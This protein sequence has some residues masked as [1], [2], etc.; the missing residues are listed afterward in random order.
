MGKRSKKIILALFTLVLTILIASVVNAVCCTEPGDNYCQ[1]TDQATCADS[2]ESVSCDSLQSICTDV[3]CCKATCESYVTR[4]YCNIA[5]AFV[6]DK[7]CSDESITECQKGCC[8][9]IDS[10]NTPHDC[11]D[12][13][14]HKGIYEKDCV[15]DPL[16]ANKIFYPGEF[17][18][19]CTDLCEAG[20]L[21]KGTIKGFVY[22]GIPK[23]SADDAKVII[24]GDLKNWIYNDKNTGFEF[25]EQSYGSHSI[26]AYYAGYKPKTEN[27][28]LSQA[29]LEI[30]IHLT[31]T[32]DKGHVSGLVREKNTGKLIKNAVV[33]YSNGQDSTDDDAF[34]FIENIDE[35]PITLTATATGYNS[36]SKPITI[37]AGELTTTNFDLTPATTEETGWLTGYVKDTT[38]GDYLNDVVIDVF[39]DN[40]IEGTGISE[41]DFTIPPKKGFYQILELPEGTLKVRASKQ[42][43]Y[44]SADIPIQINKNTGTSLEDIE[45]EP[46]PAECLADLPSPYLELSN[47]KGTKSI[48]IKWNQKCIQELGVTDYKL[49]RNNILIKT[50][51]EEDKIYE[52]EDDGS[53]IGKLRWD[54]TYT[55]KLIALASNQQSIAI[56]TIN[57]GNKFCENKLDEEFCLDNN[58]GNIIP[59]TVRAKCNNQNILS[60][61]EGCAD[62]QICRQLNDLTYCIDPDDCQNLGIDY[63]QG[64]FPNILG[65]FYYSAYAEITCLQNQNNQPRFCYM[66]YY[67]AAGPFTTVD[68]CLN[69]KQDGNCFDYQS[70]QACQQD[71][72]GY[73]DCEWY[74]NYAFAPLG[75]G[76]CYEKS[77]TGTDYC[78]LCS[79][80]NNLFSNVYCTKELCSKLGSCFATG[81][82]CESCTQDSTCELYT[83]REACVGNSQGFEAEICNPD[84]EFKYSKDTCGL[85]RCKWLNNQCIKDGNDDNIADCKENDILCQID[86]TPPTTFISSKPEA[87]ISEETEIRFITDGTSTYYCIDE[88]NCCPDKIVNNNNLVLPNEDFLLKDIK[89]NHTLYFY[90]I[91]TYNN[92]ETIQKEIIYVNTKKPK[93]TFTTLVEDNTESDT[94]SDLT[95]TLNV[96]DK[97]YCEDDLSFGY[98]NTVDSKISQDVATDL[99]VTYSALKDGYYYYTVT[100]RDELGNINET[101]AWLLIDRIKGITYAGPNNNAVVKNPVNIIIRTT[102]KNYCRYKDQNNNWQFMG[103]NK[104]QGIFDPTSGEFKY[105]AT[106]ATLISGTHN[107]DVSCH[108]DH[109]F[110]QHFDSINLAFTVDNIPPTTTPTFETVTGSYVDLISTFS[111]SQ[112]TIRLECADDPTTNF[113][114]KETKYCYDSTDCTPD[115][116]LPV[117]GIF[118]IEDINNTIL[119]YYSVDK[120]GNEE[121]TTCISLTVDST[122]PGISL[123]LEGSQTTGSDNIIISYEPKPIIVVDATETITIVEKHL[124]SGSSGTPELEQ[125][126]NIENKILK[127]Q[128]KENLEKG[129]YTAT[130]KVVD[131]IAGIGN[132]KTA[133][134]TFRVEPSPIDITYIEPKHGVSSKDT[135]NL[136]LLIKQQNECRYTINPDGYG[137]VFHTM[138]PLNKSE[139]NLEIYYKQNFNEI[140]NN[141]YRTLYIACN[142]SLGEIQRGFKYL[143]V[144]KLKP[145]FDKLEAV[146][147]TISDEPVETTLVVDTNKETICKYSTT[148]KD[149][150]AMEGKLSGY[151]NNDFNISH[152]K[153]LEF[154]TA[155]QDYKYY[156]ICEAMNGLKTDGGEVT[157]KV[158][159]TLP[160]A[161]TDQTSDYFSQGSV[162]LEIY[163]NKWSQCSYGT[164][165][166]NITL[167]YTDEG[168]MNKNHKQTL[169]LN[170]G[171]YKYYIKCVKGSETATK[172]I[173]FSIDTSPPDMLYVREIGTADYPDKSPYK[174]RLKGEWKA[175]D[176]Q[177]GIDYYN[178]LLYL[179]KY[180]EDELIDSFTTSDTNGEVTG[181]ELN[182]S[183][184]YYFEVSAVNKVGLWSDNETGDGIIIDTSLS[185]LD[186]NNREKDNDETDIDCGGSCSKGCPDNSSCKENSDCKNGFCHNDICKESTCYDGLKGPKESDKDCGGTCSK[187]C[188][189]DEKCGDDD[190]CKSGSCD[191]SKGICTEGGKCYNNKLD[192]GETDE[193]CGGICLVKC[194]NSDTCEEAYDCESN[195]C[196]E[197]ICVSA[198]KCS[199]NKLDPGETDIDCGGSCSQ[200]RN[201]RSCL[202]D[203]DCSSGN[204]NLDICEEQLDDTD[205]DGLS[206]TWED[207]YN[208]GDLDSELY[209][210]D[211]NEKSDGEEDFDKDGLINTVEEKYRT[212]PHK[213]DTDGDGYTDKEEIDKGTDPL[214]KDDYPESDMLFILFLLVALILL[215]VGGYFGYR[216]YKDMKESK[217]ELPPIKEEQILP[218]P[219]PLAG[220]PEQKTTTKKTF[221]PRTRTELDKKIEEKRKKR[222]KLLS[223]FGFGETLIKKEFEVKEE[224]KP[225]ETFEEGPKIGWVELKTPGR[226]KT[227]SSEKTIFEKLPKLKPGEDVFIALSKMIGAE[228]KQETITE[229]KDVAQKKKLTKEELLT[230]INKF[231]KQKKI[232][233]E[234][235]HNV[236][237]SIL[238]E[239]KNI[240][241]KENKAKL[242]TIIKKEVKTI[243]V[244]STQTA[245]IY[246]KKGCITIKKKKNLKTYKSKKEAQDKKLKP[247]S[248]CFPTKGRK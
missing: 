29:I 106:L 158:D 193:D 107:I 115:I 57:T 188:E 41:T 69:C 237:A 238:E 185:T 37:T 9:Q 67:K 48:K 43:Y 151:D 149:Y 137:Y 53:S 118:T 222:E 155:K 166:S 68:R 241:K 49:Y 81:D 59:L 230:I 216:K 181:L 130:I 19:N 147:H 187:K 146:P 199:N 190:D 3:G 143:R 136:T 164:S 36:E 225:T 18:N 176:N 103:I 8:V 93:F 114:C 144:D 82:S 125:I 226:T 219:K 95:V 28:V 79:S 42:G 134:L 51:K 203:D 214:D 233:E 156:V 197:N 13:Q 133:T 196:I 221:P 34:F 14:D 175:E 160:L 131:G 76:F 66:D 162:D 177:S 154:S 207:R 148:P 194:D 159:L 101:S 21:Q 170:E 100:C 55:Y 180:S 165:S 128:P 215:G 46:L 94:T 74:N 189:V 23:Q 64:Y 122:P 247:C 231:S 84:E 16:Y 248:V 38:S 192:P 234:S 33:S 212:D 75:R 208:E 1:E 2:Y 179:D 168:S 127:L 88:F 39:K 27:I 32:T 47:I 142:N 227:I 141:D 99:S 98:G 61:V 65:M 150:E 4:A 111:S 135:F 243:P 72:C 205:N 5:D 120:G 145:S 92:T 206:D 73:S 31:E 40:I 17:G 245:N 200:C 80:N 171:S 22:Y 169:S 50:F 210:T 202:T 117:N 191:I 229:F 15:A 198:N 11:Y 246:H 97:Y 213:R 209:D 139:T 129:T 138:I 172:E 218:K 52:Y 167:F 96:E 132:E 157:I 235:L 56:R 152:R 113:G 87:I 232:D 109:L 217:I 201:G 116:T 239:K 90:S 242:P 174:N 224:E 83:T 121:Q 186:C 25:T 60:V 123:Y 24:G 45:L 108:K 12:E 7:D 110:T 85:K 10:D 30:E 70:K 78:S 62:E 91:D 244:V 119:C 20:T 153:P 161:I 228:I 58:L 6:A 54:T 124:S 184:E 44:S 63:N 71:N 220:K 102:T 140:T 204:C 126:D 178:V 35:G 77:Y 236:L 183:E 211:G 173:E 182:D 104:G 112:L 26:T 195:N 163:T 240:P 86:T 89:A 105:E 223:K